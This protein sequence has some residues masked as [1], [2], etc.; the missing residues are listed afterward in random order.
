LKS[1]VT[2][3]S[4]CFPSDNVVAREI[5][6]EII[7]VPLTAGVGDADDELYTLND[8]GREIWSKLDGKRTLGQVAEELAGEYSAPEGDINR[9]VLGFA[10]ELVRRGMLA[11][12]DCAS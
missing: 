7:I 11:V 8:I 12:K 9:D 1:Q 3:N 4:I 10:A 6:G 2:L 5:E